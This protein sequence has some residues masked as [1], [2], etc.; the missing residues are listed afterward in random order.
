MRAL[1]FA[2]ESLFSSNR[3]L[4]PSP[5]SAENLKQLMVFLQQKI[6]EENAHIKGLKRISQLD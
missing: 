4:P 3:T 6:A 5:L 1:Y 2:L